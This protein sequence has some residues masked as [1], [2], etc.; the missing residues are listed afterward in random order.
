M[1]RVIDAGGA[2]A[3]HVALCA[4]REPVQ[5]EAPTRMCY[6]EDGETVELVDVVGAADP[7]RVMRK[8]RR[9]CA[10]ATSVT[11]TCPACGYARTYGGAR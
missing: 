1:A 11:H 2:A 9:S 5:I 3:S 10:H 8:V 7:E 6:C 4:E